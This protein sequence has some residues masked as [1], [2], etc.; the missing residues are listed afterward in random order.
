MEDY[1]I[2]KTDKISFIQNLPP[3]FCDKRAE[4]EMEVTIVTLF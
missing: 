4:A 1:S 2:A 3:H